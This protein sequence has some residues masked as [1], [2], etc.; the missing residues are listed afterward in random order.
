MGAVRYPTCICPS[1]VHS[2]CTILSLRGDAE[3]QSLTTRYLSDGNAQV[4]LE[5]RACR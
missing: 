3:W 4:D 2:R 5:M 1:K